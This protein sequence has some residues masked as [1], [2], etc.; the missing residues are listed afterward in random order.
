[1]QKL[2]NFGHSYTAILD[3]SLDEIELFYRSII[4]LENEARAV[5]LQDLALAVSAGFNGGKATESLTKLV[6][7]LMES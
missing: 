5:R 1:M 2:I 6:E 3:Y 4:Q 7:K